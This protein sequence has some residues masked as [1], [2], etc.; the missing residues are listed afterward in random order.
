MVLLYHPSSVGEDLVHLTLTTKLNIQDIPV[1]LGCMKNPD[2]IQLLY[3][4]RIHL[5]L[6]LQVALYL[7]QHCFFH[8][9]C[10]KTLNLQI[11]HPWLYW[12]K[13]YNSS[14][15]CTHFVYPSATIFCRSHSPP[16]S[17]NIPI[18]SARNLLQPHVTGKMRMSWP[19]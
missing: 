16:P 6:T 11:K 10:P 18:P 4:R 5:H 2:Y 17:C 8:V 14:T 13:T 9:L 19:R 1:F 7:H 3:F 15:C 12:S